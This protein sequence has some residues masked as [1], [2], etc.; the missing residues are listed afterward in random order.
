MYYNGEYSLRLRRII[1]KENDLLL[2][3]LFQGFKSNSHSLKHFT[4]FPKDSNGNR[5]S[6]DYNHLMY[7]HSVVHT[8]QHNTI[9]EHQQARP[10]QYRRRLTDKGAPILSADLDQN[11][12]QGYSSNRSVNRHGMGSHI[13][14]TCSH[15]PKDNQSN[16]S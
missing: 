6:R 11:L 16:K 15:P 9:M 7:T 2:K 1:V 5:H 3:E 14:A 10:S 4:G 13:L 12:M 8:T